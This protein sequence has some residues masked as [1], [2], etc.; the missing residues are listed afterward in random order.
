MA[1]QMV[2]LFSEVC[3]MESAVKLVVHV[4]VKAKGYVM[5]F[6]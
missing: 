4:K 6:K 5:H 1:V 3:K 2:I